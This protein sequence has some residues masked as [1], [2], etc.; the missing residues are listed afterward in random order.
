MSGAAA[1]N[2]TN[3]TDANFA[4]KHVYGTEPRSGEHVVTTQAN[5][6]FSEGFSWEQEAQPAPVVHVGPR[7]GNSYRANSDREGVQHIDSFTVSDYETG[8]E[9]M[10]VSGRGR[11]QT[12]LNHDRT[13]WR[14]F[15]PG[16]KRTEMRLW[17]STLPADPARRL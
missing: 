11:C 10:A 9:P 14:R 4:G 13:A 17:S 2:D 8:P 7:P 3:F 5:P 16:R 1:G 15:L 12:R 6:G